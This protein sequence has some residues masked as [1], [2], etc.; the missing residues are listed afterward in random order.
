MAIL[1]VDAGTTGVTAIAY[2]DGVP[3]ARAYT[4]F[5][6]HHPRPGWVE[7]DALQI[8]DAVRSVGKQVAAQCV[9]EGVGFTVQRETVVL[10]DK[11]TGKPVAPAIVWQDSRTQ[12]RCAEL[13]AWEDTVRSRTGLVI[14][15]YFSATKLEWLLQEHGARAARGELLAGTVDAWLAWKATEEHVTD[16]TNASRTM[17]FDIHKDRW[18]EELLELFGVPE[19]LLPE[20]VPSS[21]VV[22]HTG[23]FG[24]DV[25][26]AG[27][28]G[29]QQGA[30]FG[31]GCRAAGQAKNT[32]GTGCFLLQHT[33]TTAAASTHGLLTTRAASTGSAQFALEGSVFTGGAAIQWLRDKL[34]IIE[35]SPAINDLAAQT[36]STDGVMVVP[37]LSGL[38]APY[39]DPAARGAILGLTGGT[40]AP[41]VALATLQSIALQSAVLVHAMEADSGIALPELRVD[42]GAAHSDL[43]MQIQADV[44]QR[45]V[46]R[47]AD[48]ETTARGAAALA[49]LA[50]D[51]W[52]DEQESTVLF[53]P[54]KP[55]AWAE[56]KL[57][58]W[59]KAV[60]SVRLFGS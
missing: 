11:V 59:R 30:L 41:H 26:V 10:W 58:R 50:L 56:A 31:Q 25:P 54:E 8:W 52:T 34:G 7:Q 29:D 16:H 22:G 28:V 47:P 9:V 39:W 60:A 24:R 14:H 51:A 15:P 45:P 43:L 20:V 57:E 27:L 48:V 55:A 49:G 53:A 3:V 42:G 4:E 17:L 19:A 38:G 35:A 44:L 5:P 13:D 36:D 40:G 6:S 1:A 37:A 21:G 2:Q 23:V 32:Y 18:D 12:A 46:R 33:G